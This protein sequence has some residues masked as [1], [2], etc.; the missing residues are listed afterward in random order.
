M[1]PFQTGKW[2]MAKERTLGWGVRTPCFAS[3]LCQLWAV[4]SEANDLTSLNLLVNLSIKGR[5]LA[6]AGES[7]VIILKFK[8]LEKQIAHWI[9]TG[10]FWE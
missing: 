1:N 5:Y 2:L 9:L 10:I 7:G 6:G 3:H 8:S 4:W